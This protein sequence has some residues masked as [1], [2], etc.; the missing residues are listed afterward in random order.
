MRSADNRVDPAFAA[1]LGDSRVELRRLPASVPLDV[2]RAGANGFLAKA[3]K[4]D[5]DHVA[6]RSIEGPGGP[7][8]L[9]LYRPGGLTKPPIIVFLH[10]GGFILGDLESHDALCRVLAARAQAVVVAVDYRLAPEHPFPAAETDALAVLSWLE[11]ASEALD[12][13]ARRVGLAGDSAGGHIAI[14]TAAAAPDRLRHL[15]L[16]YPLIHPGPGGRSYDVYGAGHMLTTSFLDWSWE[17]Y[18]G[19]EPLTSS[20]L[21]A[22]QARL[23]RLPSATVV[24][25]QFDPLRDQGQAFARHL[26]HEGVKTR[27]YDYPGMIHGFVGLPQLTEVAEEAIGF[28]GDG[29]ALAFRD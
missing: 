9:R 15:G 10:G 8:G 6:D 20:R 2:F 7:L 23:S 11:T 19:D 18:A 29:F 24:T 21:D 14:R 28:V 3:P 1:L 12:V 22:R 27:A 26:R 4:R 25:A 5:L 17:S 16:F 13:D